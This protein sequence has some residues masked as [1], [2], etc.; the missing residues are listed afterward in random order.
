MASAKGNYF[1]KQ[2]KHL[3]LSDNKTSITPQKG[4]HKPLL[5]RAA[6]RQYLPR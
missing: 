1:L 5:V 6:N 4:L 2:K 3:P